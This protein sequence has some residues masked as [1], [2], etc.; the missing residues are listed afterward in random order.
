MLLRKQRVS[1]FDL[2]CAIFK[3]QIGDVCGARALFHR[4]FMD[5]D[6]EFIENI[7]RE[8]NMERRM[9]YT[10]SIYFLFVP[11]KGLWKS[12]IFCSLLQGNIDVACMVYE[13]AIEMAKEKH[14]LQ[15]LPVLYTNFAQFTILVGI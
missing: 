12:N 1:T 5:S 6:P 9:V 11:V 13:R 3:E 15:I 10:D 7:N 14:A 2:Y 8:A 4:N